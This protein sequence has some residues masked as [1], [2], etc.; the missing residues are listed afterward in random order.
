MISGNGDDGILIT[1]PAASS[2]TVTYNLI[3]TDEAGTRAL[4]NRSA[5][6]SIVSSNNIVTGDLIAGNGGDG[7][8]VEWGSNHNQFHANYRQ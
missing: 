8:D 5:G 4:G 7:V 1:G 6:L 2:N 3:G